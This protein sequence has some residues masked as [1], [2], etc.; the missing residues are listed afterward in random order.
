MMA[1]DMGWS[2]VGYNNGG[3]SL[4]P[5]L[6]SM[7]SGKHS[8]RFDN[9]YSGGS[10]CS[11]TRASVYSGRTP[12]RNCIWS[13]N[14]GHLH[15][16]EFTILEAAKEK[17]YATSHFGKWHLGA[18]GE[19]V[20]N[21]QDGDHTTS[22]PSTH[23]ADWYYATAHAV[24]TATPNCACH[25]SKN[26]IMG[27]HHGSV[28]GSCEAK[29]G[30]APG[31][32][33]NYFYPDENGKYGGISAE[34]EF[35]PGDDSEWLYGKFETWLRGTLAEDKSR[36]FFS[37]IWWHPPHK[38]FVATPENAQ[39][40]FD[41]GITGSESDYLGSITGIDVQIGKLRTLLTELNVADNTMLFFNSD[42][43]ALDKSP[44]G[45]N[46]EF[47]QGL[48]G[49]KHDLT[50]GGIR[51]PGILEYP[52]LIH[53][54]KVT[55]YPAATMDFLPTFMEAVGVS[56]PHPSWPLDGT[57]LMPFLRGEVESRSEPIGHLF[58]QGKVSAGRS[59]PWASW[60][61]KNGTKGETVKP[62]K[63]PSGLSEPSDAVTQK[64]C[65]ISWRIDNLKLFGWRPSV[66][67][68]WEYALFDIH[69]DPGENVNLADKQ[70]TKFSQMFKDMWAWAGGV[71]TSQ[72]SETQC[73]KG[74][75]IV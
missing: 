55:N 18:F 59:T 67:K 6:D 24:P 41:K 31:V 25:G 2:D 42:N 40:Y 66:G 56:H 3:Y 21:D 65:Q 28:L 8:I 35:I 52:A 23:G 10:V 1:D 45:K 38:D 34:E 49:Y 51:V 30:N 15:S 43:G 14:I 33:V 26:C 48:R 72:E 39:P 37:V 32:E 75:A 54:N 20:W 4:T 44:G 27:S 36:S 64:A 9:F 47:H 53:N 12:N 62:S 22:S 57:S 60:S 58:E 73:A 19:K 7:A 29:K 16:S 46:A 50:E 68:S 74:E 17:G 69:Q 13:A 61:G 70:S 71:H 11:P 63:A 5:N